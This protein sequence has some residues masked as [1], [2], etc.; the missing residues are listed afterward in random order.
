MAEM[1]TL[2]INGVTYE[3]VDAVAREALDSGSM[4]YTY[5]TE[6]LTAGVSELETGKLHFV[7]E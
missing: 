2:T 4:G 5:G 6:D 3:V 1:K 7:Y